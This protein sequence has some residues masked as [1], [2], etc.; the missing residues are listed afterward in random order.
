[1][2]PIQFQTASLVKLLK[3]QRVATLDELKV[4]LGTKVTVTV[5]RKLKAL[6]YRS[7]Y[8]HRG[9]YY[10]LDEIARFDE[11]GL[12]RF[13]DIRFSRYGTLLLTAAAFVRASERGFFASELENEL[14]AVGVKDALATLVGR[15]QLA[16]KEFSGRYLY[17]S[18]EPS[19]KRRQLLLREA[20]EE[21]LLLGGMAG[22]TL[23]EEL[24]AAIVVFYSIL[25]ERQ[26]R[27][28]AALESLKLG[29]GG[30]RKI[31]GL[32]DLDVGTVAEGRHEL[33]RREFEVE[34]IRRVGA[35][36]K[37]LEKKRRR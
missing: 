22:G 3:K 7:S 21:E 6:A 35:G 29:H 17:C 31:A 11:R 20:Q 2:R 18:P 33:L 25:D 32:L 36:R 12:W 19:K 5:F 15:D 27:L 16:R 26:R 4:A 8:S 30:D 37:P 23:P 34:R 13:R 28:Y 10:T 14:G 24:K 9:R 1:M